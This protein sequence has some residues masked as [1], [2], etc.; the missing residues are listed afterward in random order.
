MSLFSVQAAR[1]RILTQLQPIA[2]EILL[3]IR[4]ANRVLARDNA[5]AT[6][7]P[8]FDNSSRDG[9]AVRL[10][11]TITAAAASLVTLSIVADIDSGNM[12]SLI[13]ANALLIIPAGVKCVP[14]GREIDAWLL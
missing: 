7:L 13:Q 6:D 4:C 11:D 14:A 5:E 12:L 9:F 10:A 1:E 3:L 2:T 8:L